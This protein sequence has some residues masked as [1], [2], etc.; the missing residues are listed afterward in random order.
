MALTAAG[1]SIAAMAQASSRNFSQVFS[2][3]HQFFFC[4]CTV[5]FG[6]QSGCRLSRSCCKEFDNI[7]LLRQQASSEGSGHHENF[8]LSYDR[9]PEQCHT[10][11]SLGS[12]ERP[13][14]DV[15]VINDYCRMPV[16]VVVVGYTAEAH[17]CIY[18]TVMTS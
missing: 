10:D 3:C 2:R 15:L 14:N 12:A 5:P 16:G 9:N 4:R 13:A 11:P 8:P 6:S 17:Y 18:T 7:F 1:F